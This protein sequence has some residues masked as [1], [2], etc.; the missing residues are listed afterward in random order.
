MSSARASSERRFLFSQPY[1]KVMAS[2]FVRR[3]A[4]IPVRIQAKSCSLASDPSRYVVT[5]AEKG[6][7][8]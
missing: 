4:K 7:R 8:E 5:F 3:P 1:A 2:R 6:D